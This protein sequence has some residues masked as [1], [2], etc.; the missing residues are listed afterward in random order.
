MA[1][2]HSYGKMVTDGLVLYLNAAD[3]NSYVSGSTTWRDLAGSNNGTLTN[4][5]TYNSANFGSI[6]F[7]GVNDYVVCTNALS[8]TNVTLNVWFYF[9]NLSD[10][11]C[12]QSWNYSLTGGFTVEIYSSNLLFAVNGNGSN[13]WP[14]YNTSNLTPG[15]WYNITGTLSSNTQSLYLNGTFI[16]SV[17]DATRNNANSG[18]T[19]TVGARSSGGPGSSFSTGRSSI[20][21]VYNRALSA[22]EVL[23]NYNATKARFGLT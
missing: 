20:T 3:A 11:I 16:T 10:Q 14:Q 7:D 21:Q 19:L 17:T 5:P 15:R 2:Q 23:Q 13:N 18:I 22:S 4:G 9:T 1:V 8:L 6:V 12:A